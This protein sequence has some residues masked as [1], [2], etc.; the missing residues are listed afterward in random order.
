MNEI[1]RHIENLLLEYKCVIVPHLGGFVTQYVSARYV[2]DEKL[3]LPPYRSVGFNP[4]LIVNDGLLVQSY[5]RVYDTSYTETI[6]MIEDAV[7]NLK[8]ELQQNGCYELNGVGTLNLNIDGHYN[9]HPINSGILAPEL[10]G[11]DAIPIQELKEKR[12]ALRSQEATI[13]NKKNYTI[14]INRELINYTAAAIIAIVCY[15][16][17]WGD[18]FILNNDSQPHQAAVVPLVEHITKEVDVK[19]GDTL[20]HKQ[21]KITDLITINKQIVENHH[22]RIANTPTSYFTIVLASSVSKK[23]A[24]TCIKQLRSDGFQEGNILSKSKMNRVVYGKYATAQE[25]HKALTLYKKDNRFE[26]GWILQVP[27]LSNL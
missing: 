12:V 18:S 5:M 1:A 27:K 23:N 9:F 19:V 8:T 22:Q 25:A 17:V 24:K 16:F 2:E 21:R 4:Q 7:F 11:L 14:S 6:Q 13:S 3:F 20:V 15:F 10:F 26:Q